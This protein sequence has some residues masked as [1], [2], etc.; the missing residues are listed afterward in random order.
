MT[1]MTIKFKCPHCE[2]QLGAG[3]KLIGTIGSCPNCGKEITVPEKDAETQ[4]D[5]VQ[6][7]KK[8]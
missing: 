6:T 7:A 8:E 1:V 3:I 5:K 2:V 4:S